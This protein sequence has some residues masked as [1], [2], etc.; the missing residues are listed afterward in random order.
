MKYVIM[1]GGYYDYWKTPKQLIKINNERL[2]DRTIRLLRKNGI[3]DIYIT[4]NNPIFDTCD[5]I[6][7]EHSNNYSNVNGQ[8]S[9]YWLDAYYPFKNSEKICYLYGDVYYSEKAIKTIIKYE[10]TENTLFGTGIA[11]NKL[12]QNW[13]EPF[14]YKVFNNKEFKD[15][16]EK[17]K[18]MYDAG[19][20]KRMPITWE[21]YR[22]LHGLDINKQVI[23]E[24]YVVIDDETQD[25]DKPEALEE[26]IKKLGEYNV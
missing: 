9:G 26:A 3:E 12:Y 23:T 16:I 21:L 11:K 13:G 2:V 22:V 25:I 17:A 14:A 7:L 19:Q 8:E 6:R 4:S 18:R 10:S 5:A 20:T 15:G 24:D 1:C